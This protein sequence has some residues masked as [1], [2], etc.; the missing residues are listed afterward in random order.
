[1]SEPIPKF[2]DNPRP[3]RLPYGAVPLAPW[4]ALDHEDPDRLYSVASVDRIEDRLVRTMHDQGW[5]E[6]VENAPALFEV[7]RTAVV[8]S[9]MRRLDRNNPVLSREEMLA[10]SD[11]RMG[12]ALDGTASPGELLELLQVY[13]E[14][15]SLEL[16]K[17]SHPFDFEA[18]REMDGVMTELILNSEDVTLLDQAPRYKMKRA[19]AEIPAAIVLRKDAL[20]NIRTAKGAIQIIERR[21][22]LVYKGEGMETETHFDRL[23]KNPERFPVLVGKI[24]AY[25]G[26]STQRTPYGWVQPQATSYYAKYVSTSVQI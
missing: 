20:A 21:G 6:N 26:D 11:E 9:Q 8:D 22:L 2:A 25:L 5:F 12:R 15:G 14:L 3:A 16:A 18:S 23:V 24:N 4:R 13:P 7:M 1:M 10:K 19:A 17:L